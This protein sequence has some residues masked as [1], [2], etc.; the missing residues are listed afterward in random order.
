MGIPQ[1]LDNPRT[2]AILM[3]TLEA[4]ERSKEMPQTDS[5]NPTLQVAEIVGEAEKS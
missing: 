2:G 3:N 4:M 5:G 1:I